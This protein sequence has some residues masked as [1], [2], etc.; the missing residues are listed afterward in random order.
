ER[1]S[2]LT[3]NIP[4][5]KPLHAGTVHW[6]SWGDEGHLRSRGAKEQQS[7]QEVRS[8]SLLRR[9]K[10]KQF[11]QETSGYNQYLEHGDNLDSEDQV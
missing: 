6:N 10:E 1:Q 9:D 11:A 2:Q 8:S 5:I 7:P 3:P 4:K